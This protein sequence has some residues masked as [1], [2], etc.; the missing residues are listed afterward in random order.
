[1]EKQGR[2]AELIE[3]A[4]QQLAD[5]GFE[6]LRTRD[7][8]DAV[9]VNVATLHYYFPTKEAL[10]KGVVGHALT[11]FQSTLPATGSAV[12]QL[13]AHFNGLRRLSRSDP[14]LFAVMG[15][16]ALRA[17]RDRGLAATIRKTDEIWHSTLRELLRRAQKEG[18][19]RGSDPDDAAGLIVAA[20]KG[21]FML[22]AES[23]NPQRL[24]QAL[25]QL[26]RWLGLSAR[27][28]TRPG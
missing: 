1:M 17:A 11:R 16:L 22:P 25:D 14:E 20:L 6:G 10:I 13:S 4:Y 21:T 2:R 12:E 15:E 19:A 9:G 27:K 5:H 18:I 23:R 24:D 28:S 7:V 3:A 26:E 8:A